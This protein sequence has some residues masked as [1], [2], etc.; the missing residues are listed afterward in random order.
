MYAQETDTLYDKRDG[1]T[2][3]TVKIGNQWWMAE[4]LAYKPSIGEYYAYRNNEGY[5]AIYGYLYNWKTAC[6]VCPKGWH[7]P[8]DK[9]WQKLEITLGMS[10]LEAEDFKYRGVNIGSKLAGNSLLWRNGILLNNSKFGSSGFLALPGG[11]SNV[12]N[13]R[14]IDKSAYFWSSTGENSGAWLRVLS[15]NQEGISRIGW[16]KAFYFSVRCVKD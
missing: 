9:E 16:G 8:S 2:Y 7:L 3:K 5:V 13:F 12:V 11:Y 4:N 14:D 10:Q 15:F 6:N 1:K